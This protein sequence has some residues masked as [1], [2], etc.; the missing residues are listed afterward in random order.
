MKASDANS[1]FE[2]EQWKALSSDIHKIIL[3]QPKCFNPVRDV[4]RLYDV[5]EA[6][7]IL[8]KANILSTELEFHEELITSHGVFSKDGHDALLKAIHAL[9][10]DQHCKLQLRL[11]HICYRLPQRTV[12]SHGYTCHIKRAVGC[13]YRSSQSIPRPGLTIGKSS[14]LLDM[15]K[16]TARRCSGEVSAVFFGFAGIRRVSVDDTTYPLMKGLYYG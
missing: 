15:E 12:F 6:Y 11:L 2:A 4:T 16:I 5:S 9:S 3:A 8:R 10:S 13:G 7:N 14:L 1:P